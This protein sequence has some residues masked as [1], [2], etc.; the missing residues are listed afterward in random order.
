M[1]ESESDVPEPI[2]LSPLSARDGADDR[3]TQ[4]VMASLAEREENVLLGALSIAR[5]ALAAAAVAAVIA[6]VTLERGETTIPLAPATTSDMAAA[7][8]VA[9]PFA[10]AMAEGAERPRA[11]DLLV[12]YRRR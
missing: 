12:N 2:D 7:L 6:I 1:P 3:I 11:S 5:P 9:G 8:G 4:R 10:A